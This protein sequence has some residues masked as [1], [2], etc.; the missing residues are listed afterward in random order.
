MIFKHFPPN[1]NF[2]TPTCQISQSVNPLP[3]ELLLFENTVASKADFI[4]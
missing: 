3:N 2:E 4:F 1:F